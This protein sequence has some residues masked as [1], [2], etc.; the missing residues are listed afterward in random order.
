V[1]QVHKN[2]QFLV[3]MSRVVAFCGIARPEQFFSGLRKLGMDL[4]DT[5]TFRD[6]HRYTQSDIERLLRAQARTGAKGFITTDKDAINLG[7]LV[8]QLR[9]FETAGLELEL[10]DGAQALETMLRVLEERCG[11]RF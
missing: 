1:W 8:S 3:P 10:K 4:A 5:H 2:I 7:S 6:H 11:C 9:T